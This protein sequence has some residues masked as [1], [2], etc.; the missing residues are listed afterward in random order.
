MPAGLACW[1]DPTTKVTNL[2]IPPQNRGRLLAKV[3]E[4]A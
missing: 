3:D 4:L 2:L 1:L